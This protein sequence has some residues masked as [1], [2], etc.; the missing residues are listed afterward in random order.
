MKEKTIKKDKKKTKKEKML[1]KQ[2]RGISPVI[3]VVLL[4][5]IT[6][7]AVSIV[8]SFVKNMVEEGLEE[9]STCFDLREHAEIIS[10]DYTCYNETETR[11]M[12]E[13]DFKEIEIKG[14]RV[15]ITYEGTSEVYDL[16][17]GEE[18]EG[19]R[20]LDD[21]N[22]IKIPNAGGG[23]TYVF[24]EGGK[25]AELGIITKNE[26]ICKISSYNIPECL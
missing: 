21:S 22:I 5:L 26:R 8:W 13:R 11:I 16:I 15:S 4:V 18:T 1:K 9:S 17:D 19:A 12:I 2:K 6:F 10:S 23:E 25:K 20:M 14:F 3:A 24:K 7:I